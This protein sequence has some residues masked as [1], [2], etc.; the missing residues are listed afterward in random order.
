MREYL[1]SLLEI[2]EE[3]EIKKKEQYNDDFEK[4]KAEYEEYITHR[5]K[6]ESIK[7]A[8]RRNHIVAVFLTV[9]FGIVGIHKFYIGKM[10]KGILK[11]AIFGLSLTF[12]FLGRKSYYL[13][14][15]TTLIA[16]GTAAAIAGIAWWWYDI[17]AVCYNR[18][19][20]INDRRLKGQS[21]RNNILLSYFTIIFGLLGIHA[22]YINKGKQGAVKVIM[23]ITATTLYLWSEYLKYSNFM[24]ESSTG[25][26][27]FVAS[28]VLFSFVILWWMLDVYFV[29]SDE[30]ISDKFAIVEDKTRSQAVAILFAVFGGM[31]G[32]DR[33]YLGYR[34][35]GILKLFTLG[36]FG[37][38]YILDVI[39]IYLNV[40]KDASGK[41]MELE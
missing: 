10:G 22:I 3:I 34:T 16:I 17:Y 26:M 37:I 14:N 20:D 25:E 36:G 24:G 7:D 30:Y 15:D 35:L 18:I 27:I 4:I 5:E 29:L 13:Y 8:E 40:L 1:N 6:S 21:H 38:S 28:I 23:F 41:E 9:L 31:F 32:L 19:F 39:L 2:D 33:F 11:A 12:I